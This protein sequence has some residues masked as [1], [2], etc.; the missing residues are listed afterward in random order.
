MIKDRL[1][2]GALAGTAGAVVQNTY[3]FT[4]ILAGY[5]GPSYVD[6]GKAIVF[7]KTIEGP[8]ALALGLIGH[9]VWNIILGVIFAYIIMLTSSRYYLLKGI[10]YGLVVWFLIKMGSSM[11]EIAEIV[12]INPAAAAVFLSG[13]ILFGVAIAYTLKILDQSRNLI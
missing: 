1:V 10:I 8:S 11:F 9:F 4:L 6:Y 3:A 5:K 12:E 2:N 13:A 7:Y